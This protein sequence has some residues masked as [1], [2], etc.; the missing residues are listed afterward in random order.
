M[1][2]H[3]PQICRC[4]KLQPAA[5]RMAVHDGNEGLAQPGKAIEHAVPL[6]YPPPPHVKWFER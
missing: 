3:N 1:G 2:L 4:S 6:A 5:Q